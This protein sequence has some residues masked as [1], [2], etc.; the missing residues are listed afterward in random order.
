[1]LFVQHLF[2]KPSLF[3]GILFLSLFTSNTSAKTT[4]PASTTA[5]TKILVWGDSLSAAYGIPVD[6]GWVNLLKDKLGDDYE[7]INGSISGETSQGGL[8]RITSALQTHTPDLVILEL[9]ANDGLRGISPQVT[10]HNLGQIIQQSKESNANIMLLGIKIPP[11]Y[12][13]AFTQRFDAQ[14]VELANE[15]KLPFI[16]FFLSKLIGDINLFQADQ[17]HPT[18]EAQPIILE[19]ILPV[20]R[21]ALMGEDQIEIEGNETRTKSSRELIKTSE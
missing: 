17:L 3:I 13:V 4:T 21:E 15:Y 19:T 12:G 8:S 5:T 1:M 14:F 20:L 11:N 2:N 7:V 9:G 10:K 16:P 18:I 6:K